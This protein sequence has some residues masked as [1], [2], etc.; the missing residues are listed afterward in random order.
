MTFT[1]TF[2]LTPGDGPINNWGVLTDGN[3]NL[4]TIIIIIIFIGLIQ[5]FLMAG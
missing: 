1:A 2:K 3:Y 4:L 5:C